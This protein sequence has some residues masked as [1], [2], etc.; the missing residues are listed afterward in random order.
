M[1]LYAG[2]NNALAASPVGCTHCGRKEK[3]VSLIAIKPTLPEVST[4]APLPI[5]PIFN[6]Y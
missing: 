2:R 3:S 6:N 1:L 5:Q 4:P